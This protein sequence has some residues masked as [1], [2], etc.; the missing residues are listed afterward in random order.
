[1]SRAAELC[2]PDVGRMDKRQRQEGRCEGPRGTRRREASS[3]HPSLVLQT[4]QKEKKRTLF[5]IQLLL[6]F[7][8]IDRSQSMQRQ[9]RYFNFY[10]NTSS[11]CHGWPQRAPASFESRLG[12]QEQAESEVRAEFNRE[13]SSAP[14]LG[15][16]GG[17]HRG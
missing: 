9:W 17:S 11:E 7:F 3:S 4:F 16:W 2:V 14:G 13:R 6:G 5:L 15:P 12:R 10:L 1:M 8:I